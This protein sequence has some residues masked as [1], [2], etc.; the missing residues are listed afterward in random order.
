MKYTLT[1]L[2][3]ALLALWP[4]ALAATQSI[5]VPRST[6]APKPLREPDVIY[7]PTPFA[8]VDAMLDLGDVKRGDVLYDLGSGDGRIPVTAAARFGIRA[9]G[10]DINPTRIAEARTNAKEAKLTD[11]VTFRNEDL[12]ETDIGE[13]TVVTLYLLPELNDKLRPRLL[14][15]LKPGTRVVSH[16][17]GMT[18]WKPEAT[19]EVEG[20]TIYL[21]RIP[22]Q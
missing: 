4:A 15:M 9:V 7:V 1:V 14:K 19:R 5:A 13:A 17:F 16:A 2:L 8:V 21:W 20:T 22:K 18:D 3:P 10:V 12:F 11:R 6:P